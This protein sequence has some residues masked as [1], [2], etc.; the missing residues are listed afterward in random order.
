MPDDVDIRPFHIDDAEAVWRMRRQPGVLEST[1]AMPS[2]RL[3]QRRRR[4]EALG[5]DDHMF[6]AVRHGEI[7]GIAGLHVEDGRRRHVASLGIAVAVTHQRAGV[8]DA[9]MRAILDVADRWLG[10]RRIELGVLVDN[11]PARRLYEKHGFVP[12]GVARQ[13]VAGEGRL[14]DE[15]RMARLRPAMPGES[16]DAEQRVLA[17]GDR[18][19][20]DGTGETTLGAADDAQPSDAGADRPV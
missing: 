19:R 15:L 11:E 10:L 17:A 8:G 18:E 7:A 13:S 5:D 1:M 12:E 6:V 14:Q 4:F 9:L 16:D 3:D 20:L 2:E